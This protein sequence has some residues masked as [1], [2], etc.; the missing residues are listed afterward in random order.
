VGPNKNKSLAI[1]VDGVN[2]DRIPIK[3]HL[4]TPKDDIIELI[5]KYV[6]PHL[7]VGDHIFISEQIIAIAQGR[8]IPIKDVRPSSFAKYLS[9]RIGVNF[10]TKKFRGF[11]LG[12]P[13][14]MQLAIQEVGLPR[15]LLGA[16]VAAVTKPFGIK[17]MFYRVIGPRAKA[18][19][20]PAS[21]TLWPYHQYAKL[22][23]LDPDD[24]A[25]SIAKETGHETVIID[26]N[27]I[28]V[29]VLG[30]SSDQISDDFAEKVFR[31]NPLGQGDEQTPLCIV[32]RHA[33]SAA[34][35]V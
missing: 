15:I 23:P 21:Y 2:F 11:G 3:T 1:E 18:I 4:I 28:G 12:T 27:Y 17:G 14:A 16:A 33:G 9:K 13:P 34:S 35:A 25:R 20:C 6:V 5:R 31:D 29:A 7:V 8:I 30:K 32:R 24:V 10:G 26:A 22:A 19:D